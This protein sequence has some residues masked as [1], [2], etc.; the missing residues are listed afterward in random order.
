[1][2]RGNKTLAVLLA[3]GCPAAA[4][5]QAGDDPWLGYLFDGFFLAPAVAAAYGEPRR[6]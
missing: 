6:G 2:R 1:M 4:G 5:A 3:L